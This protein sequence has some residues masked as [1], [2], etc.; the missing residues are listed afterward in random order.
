MDITA[1]KLFVTLRTPQDAQIVRDG[2]SQ[3][4]AEYPNALL[5]R[6]TPA[7]QA[8]L[9]A[10]GISAATLA[11]P[12]IQLAGASFDL[13]QVLEAE[14]AAPIVTDPNRTTY[15]LLQLIGPPKGEWLEAIR[16]HGGAI[17]GNLPGF[18]VLIGILPAAV[19]KL[20]AEPWVE[21]ITPYRPTMKVSAQLRP[22]AGAVLSATNLEAFDL[23]AADPNA[24]E[25]IEISV[26]PK[27]S[28]ADIAALVRAANGTVLEETPQTVIA[29][30]SSATI[31]TL[32]AQPGVEAIIPHRFSELHNDRATAVMGAPA[33][34]VFGDL[35]LR[36]TGQIVAIADSGLD[37]GVAATVHPDINGRV[38][39]IASFPIASA[40]QPYTNDVAPF[41]DGAA[42]QFSAHG[43]HVTGSVLGNGAAASAA[44]SPSVPIGMAP[45]AQ[46]YFQAIEQ[47]VHWKTVAQLT[48][49]G[50]T[51]F[52]T[53]W[54]PSAANL[55]GIPS[56]L[57][58]VFDPAYIA[59]ARIH[60]NSW[61]ASSPAVHGVY[62]TNART[63][64]NYMWTHRDMLILFSAG[65]DGVDTD[66]DAIIDGDSIGPP[67]TAKNCLTVGAS[68]NDRPHGSTPTPG[69]DANWTAV[70][71]GGGVSY[72]ALGSAGHISDR[73]D[74]MA[75][76]SSRG[77]TDDGR[78]KPDVVAPGTNI[79]SVRSSVYVGPPA[80]PLWG[81]V[82]APDP[83]HNLYCWSGGTSMSTP[84][85]AGAAALIRQHLVQQRGH[86]QPNVK[87]SGA[88]IKAFLVNGA[89]SIPGQFPTEIP[90]GQQNTV[91]GF[92]RVNVAG[93][94]TPSAL[95]QTLFA[96]EPD[97]A[98]ASGELRTF[99][100]QALDLAQPLKVTLV[101]TDA[102]S[103]VNIGGLQNQLY[104]QIV[105]P[106][107]AALDGDVSAFP[108]ASNN[109]QQVV[110]AAPVAGTYEIRVN[111]VS[112]TQHAPGVPV[113]MNPRQDF[114]LAVSNAMGLSVQPV[115]IAQAIDTTGSMA[116][117]GYMAPAQERA[118]QL[119]DF[120]RG[121]DKLSISEFSQRPAVPLARTPY[122]LHL[123]TNFTPDWTDAHTAIDGL[124]AE[125]TTPIGAGLLEAWSQLHLEPVARPRAII[126]LSDG[127]ENVAPF[128]DAALLAM[129]PS[130]VPIFT[131]A[132]GPAGSAPTL[133]T[134]A[135]S[136]PN[137]GYYVVA[138]D[139]DIHK[140]HEIYAQLQALAAGAAIIGLSSAQ[141]ASEGSAE[142]ALVVDADVAEVT[143]CLSWEGA[144]QKLDL[145]VTGPDGRSYTA[146]TAATLVRAG[147]TYAIMSV[148]LPVAGVWKIAVR[149]A[150]SELPVRY[151]LSGAVRSSLT[152]AA[153]VTRASV[154]QLSLLARLRQ[155]GRPLDQ[156]EVVARITLPT[157]SLQDVLAQFGDKIRQTQL[158]KALDESGMSEQARLLTQLS[159][160]ATGF[161]EKEGGLFERRSFDVALVP[162][163]DGEWTTQVPLTVPGNVAVE[164]IARG[165]RKG[166]P[167][168]RFAGLAA[169]VASAD[170]FAP[171]SN[172]WK[173]SEIFAR[174]SKLWHYRII[175]AR[176]SK[177]DGQPM[178]PQDGLK[179]R[180]IVAQNGHTAATEA[181]PYYSVGQYYIWR[182]AE[183]GFTAGSATVT[184]QATLGDAVV[185]DSTAVKL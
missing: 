73:P 128:A 52:L 161:R 103:P 24:R 78:I 182:F 59:G 109:V 16:A 175:G 125:G 19:P 60:T 37:T 57:T 94:L 80:H 183:P 164:V 1:T 106:G 33:D 47:N 35:T 140:L 13:G 83:L 173:I 102:P 12:A 28:T 147:A 132:L 62:N 154:D 26:F 176:L 32:A 31:N 101:W 181:L 58:N 95:Q 160:F 167:W 39:G 10:S 148:G 72:P 29:V 85:V 98:V 126:L 120:M 79:L 145:A 99:E 152:L 74:G 45:E 68:E 121:G 111:G 127:L 6:S 137:G 22:D 61:G 134:I 3:V 82:A 136:R 129:I 142:H 9:R 155:S 92:G 113:G 165:T 116:F 75:A 144:Q 81:D 56:N 171:K 53:P 40:L 76:F 77:P 131:V 38:A 117:F 141:V 105:P 158:P 86:F 20:Q 169:Q 4:L 159:V 146:T 151:T 149:N 157:R 178:R 17:E 15:Y 185:V 49:S 84:L 25:Q 153:E 89:A 23:S 90:A 156:A 8:A 46:V 143:F 88:L 139:E 93:S 18:V 55:W 91:D 133:Q 124:H 170:V 115:S 21:A 168:E 184:V 130:D 150:K 50:L 177:A 114:A 69:L 36:G 180:M 166:V 44:G 14:I 107:A 41:D 67:A 104:L 122:P 63:V 2:G 51:P 172:G 34:R 110:I 97:L 71:F 174:S 163:G 162:H 96:D 48:A 7:Q 108:I 70:T 87:P 135:S 43:T 100:V 27:E 30:V 42:D 66:S 119:L 179:L 5:I 11:Q 118:A 123:L 54:P 65:N 138:S 112:V 64:D